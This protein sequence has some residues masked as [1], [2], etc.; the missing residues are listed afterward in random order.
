M[1][2]EIAII[3]ACACAHRTFRHCPGTT[4]GKQVE[5]SLDQGAAPISAA[6]LGR[7][8]AVAAS[9]ASHRP[10]CASSSLDLT[11]FLVQSGTTI[12]SGADMHHHN[13]RRRFLCRSV[14]S[15][16]RSSLSLSTTPVTNASA[17]WLID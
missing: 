17:R 6:L 9:R 7:D 10:H 8:T 2:V 12:T 4:F 13:G 1:L 14:R 16:T 5:R 3:E 11:T 15:A